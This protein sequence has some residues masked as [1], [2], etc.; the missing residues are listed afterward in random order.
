MPDRKKVTFGIPAGT[1]AVPCRG[2]GAWIYWIRTEK[3]KLMP[4]DP[5]GAPHWATC[6][7]AAEFRRKK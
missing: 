2:C 7:K 3:G 1:P 6:P 5:G 4:V